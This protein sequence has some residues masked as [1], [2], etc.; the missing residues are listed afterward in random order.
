M[1]QLLHLN[2]LAYTISFI[3]SKIEVLD[4]A[5]KPP[6]PTPMAKNSSTTHVYLGSIKG[7]IT[8]AEFADGSAGHGLSYTAFRR[9]LEAFLNQFYAAHQLSHDKYLEI[10]HNQKVIYKSHCSE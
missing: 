9:M 3:R 6:P 4:E 5:T 8:V 1:R 2:H 7:E 10:R